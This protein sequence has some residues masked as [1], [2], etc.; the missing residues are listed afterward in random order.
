MTLHQIVRQIRNRRSLSLRELGALATTSHSTLSAYE[1]GRISPSLETVDRIVR[2]A[3][4]DMTITL[5]TR[6]RA[7]NNLPR[8]EELAQ[9]LLL[10]AEF[11]SNPSAT[12]TTRRF[13]A[14]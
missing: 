6:I 11:P 4:L 10:A 5:T 12:I 9:V 1:H 14:P 3:N 13:P 8:G 7:S 2:V